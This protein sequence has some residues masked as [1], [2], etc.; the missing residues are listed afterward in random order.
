MF[1]L[2]RTSVRTLMDVSRDR[3]ER[4]AGVARNGP[5]APP[6]PAFAEAS[7]GTISALVQ[8]LE[9]ECL[10]LRARVAETERSNTDLEA[11]AGR[12]AHELRNALAPVRLGCRVLTS[13]GGAELRPVAEA[14][15]RSLHGALAL[16]DALLVFSR[17]ACVET[18]GEARLDAAVAAVLDELG[19][20]IRAADIELEL[21]GIAED[22]WV[23]CEPGL[24]HI[25]LT[26]VIGN[27]V[28]FLTRRELRLLR[29]RARDEG[30]YVAVTVED[31]GPGIPPE[32]LERIF[33]PFYRVPCTGTDGHGL[34]LAT[35]RRILVARGGQVRILS[36]P[37]RGTQVT[38]ELTARR[39]TS[40]PMPAPPR[41]G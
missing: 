4:G 10:L 23:G 19:P 33:E 16:L 26:N 35:V 6:P 28:K 36:E 39:R 38:V 20:A 41:G 40:T 29:V 30:P 1:C 37:G 2:K 27:A 5:G 21:V 7:F 34:G 3:V 25:V 8:R 11:F 9:D 22:R 24:L 17:V 14:M 31:T 18:M 12:A 15:E 32:A 13:A